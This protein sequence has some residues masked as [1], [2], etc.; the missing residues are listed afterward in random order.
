[1]SEH[2]WLAER[3]ET[4]CN[5]PRAVAHRMLGPASETND[6]VQADESGAPVPG[7]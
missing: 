5:H 4:N 6:A 2:D 1:M 3:C 7:R